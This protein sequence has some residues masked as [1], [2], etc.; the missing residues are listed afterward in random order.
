MGAVSYL[1]YAHSKTEA[2]VAIWN[3]AHAIVDHST[4]VN[5]TCEMQRPNGLWY[6]LGVRSDFHPDE[7]GWNQIPTTAR[8]VRAAQ[9]NLSPLPAGYA[10]SACPGTTDQPGRSVRDWVVAVSASAAFLSA[11]LAAR[12]FIKRRRIRTERFDGI[13]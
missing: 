4:G 1:P 12:V 10:W 9:M 11:L 6:K 2:A 3:G 8:Y 7:P 13:L 5:V